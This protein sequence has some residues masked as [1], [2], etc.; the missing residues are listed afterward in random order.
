M[1]RPDP[2]QVHC[3]NTSSSDDV[4]DHQ[5]PD[6]GLSP[7]GWRW[8]LAHGRPHPAPSRQPGWPAPRVAPCPAREV[9]P[10]MAIDP[11]APRS[12]RALLAASMGGLAAVTARRS[13]DHW[14]RTRP[15]ARRSSSAASTPRARRRT[16]RTAP[17]AMRGSRSGAPARTASASTARVRDR[18]RRR[19]RAGRSPR[20]WRPVRGQGRV[21]QRRRGA[22]RY[23]NG[24]AVYGIADSGTAVR[25][26][27]S[28]GIAIWGSSP[29]GLGMR[30][31]WE[32]RR[33]RGHRQRGPRRQG[34]LECDPIGSQLIAGVVGSGATGVAGVRTGVP[35]VPTNT[36]VFGYSTAND[37]SRGVI[38]SRAAARACGGSPRVGAGSTARRRAA[39]GCTRRPRPGPP[40]VSWVG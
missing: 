37:S 17:Q 9:D 14:R 26:E 28:S 31:D 2:I 10:A 11:A 6:A 22:R 29:N 13:A 33:P 20:V 32:V 21:G 16:S 35:S 40:S 36:G 34:P 1:T 38:G 39:R 7:R 27:S 5:G 19:R 24:D 3:G 30:A 25:G 12:R 23:R 15:T 8:P 18:W 4:T